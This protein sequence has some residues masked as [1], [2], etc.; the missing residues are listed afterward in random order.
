MKDL[1]LK[2]MRI[3]FGRCPKCGGTGE[4]TDAR[5]LKYFLPPLYCP[6]CDI[7]YSAL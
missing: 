6:R 4:A 1:K 2:L 3:F 5:A 7:N